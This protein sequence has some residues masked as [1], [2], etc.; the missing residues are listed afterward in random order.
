MGSTMKNVMAVC[1]VL[2][3]FAACGKMGKAQD[4]NALT[5]VDSMVVEP[6]PADSTH[7][8]KATFAVTFPPGWVMVNEGERLVE[9]KVPD[10]ENDAPWAAKASFRLETLPGAFRTAAAYV[11]EKVRRDETV[12]ALDDVTANGITWKVMA[13][14][15]M[16]KP[17][18]MYAPLPVPGV[19]KVYMENVGL[20]DPDVKAILESITL[21]TPPPPDTLAVGMLQGDTIAIGKEVGR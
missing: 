13:F 21:R 7:I 11:T 18:M 9:M 14:D 1:V 12:A 10:P 5:D 20:E 19:A 15:A 2:L 16:D 8:E 4:D 6:L 17:I 3:C